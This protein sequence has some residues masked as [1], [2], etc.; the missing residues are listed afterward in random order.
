MQNWFLL[1]IYTAADRVFIDLIN[2]LTYALRE[3]YI[4]EMLVFNYIWFTG[5]VDGTSSYIS[6]NKYS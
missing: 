2:Y 6:Y 5:A 4:F 1:L 3:I